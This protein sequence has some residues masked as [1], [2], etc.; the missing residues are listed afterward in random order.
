MYNFT[1]TLTSALFGGWV[2][3]QGRATDVFSPVPIV[4]GVEYAQGR[5][6][7]LQKTSSLPGF[8]SGLF[9]P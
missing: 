7:Q 6:G 2:G 8:D 1:F 4:Q 3:S 9:G 5:S